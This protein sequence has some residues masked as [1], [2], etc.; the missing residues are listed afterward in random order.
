MRFSLAKADFARLLSATVK[1]VES[2]NTIPI[3]S[4]V[5]LTVVGGKLTATASDLDIEVS[6]SVQLL[7]AIDGAICVDART[8]DSIVKKAAGDIAL[9]TKDGQAIVSFG[10]SRFTLAV[11]PPEDFP[12]MDAGTFENEFEA[13]LAELFA[14]CRFAMSTEETRYYL[15]G[16]FLHTVNGALTA[17][18]TDGHRLSSNTG[19][20]GFDFDGVIVPRKTVDTM[21]TGKVQVALSRTKIRITSG[22]T[23]MT[24]KLI[25]GTFP[26]YQ[27]IIPSANANLVRFDK[28]DMQA[29]VDRVSL[30]SEKG[31]AAKF[32]FTDGSADIFLRGDGAE[33]ADSLVCEI[34]ADPVEIGFNTRY[35][36]DCLAALP[37]GE[38]VMELN[39][40]GS[41]ALMRGGKEGLKMVLMPM[42][43]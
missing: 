42:R 43:V 2:R 41:P 5:R 29:A 4:T 39:D 8:L 30:I 10:R 26:D 6:A 25:D 38:V 36:I 32:A 15:N 35:M 22:D 28:V 24:S 37:D 21:L 34:D 14:P 18:A 13:D 27:R 11:L 20:G 7:D 17:V 40:A 9:E 19:A 12:T 16:V 33:A 31:R 23:V 3:L 1:V